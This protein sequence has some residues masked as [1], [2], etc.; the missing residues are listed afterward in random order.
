LVQQEKKIWAERGVRT[1]RLEGN[2][3]SKKKTRKIGKKAVTKGT[4]K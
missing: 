2:A 3:K 1:A 4:G